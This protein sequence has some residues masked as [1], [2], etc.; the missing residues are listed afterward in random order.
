MIPSASGAV[1]FDMDGVLIDS[2]PLWQ[3]AEID[4]FASVGVA[5]TQQMCEQHTGV[6]IDEV[7]D[8]YYRTLPWQGKSQ[9]QVV[10]EIVAFTAAL[11]AA[12][13]VALPGALEAVSGARRRAL[14][15][16][17]ATSSPFPIID[18]VL[19]RLGLQGQF[20][21]VCSAQDEPAGKPDPAVYLTAARRLGMEPAHCVVIEDAISGIR[22]G[23]AAGMHVIAVPPSHL[24]DDPRY[25]LA[26]RRLGSLT[27]LCL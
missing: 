8:T 12:E 26:D 2:E 17:L 5:V 20:D 25:A 1:I 21:A 27:E 14:K 3:Q 10:E 7:V 9:A 15:V 24:A 22:A 11:I 19:C 18:A 4:V 6:R 13:G 16:G 23:R